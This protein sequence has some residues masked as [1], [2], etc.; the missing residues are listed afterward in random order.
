MTNA[1]ADAKY[2]AE[3]AEYRKTMAAHDAALAQHEQALA[4]GEAQKALA[5]RQD[6]RCAGC[7]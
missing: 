2:E 4:D 1:E 3:M 7:S 5:M 6:V